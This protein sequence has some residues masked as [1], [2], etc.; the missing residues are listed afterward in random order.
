MSTNTSTVIMEHVQSALRHAETY[1]TWL[2][3]FAL[4]SGFQSVCKTDWTALDTKLAAYRRSC[5][6][7]ALAQR[8]V[9]CC[10]AIR[11]HQMLS[12]YNRTV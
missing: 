11:S 4:H 6:V 1:W 7:D 10:L 9:P 12:M 8:L 5:A 2:T 3:L